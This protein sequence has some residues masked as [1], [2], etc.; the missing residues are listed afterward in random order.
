MNPDGFKRKPYLYALAY[1]SLAVLLWSGHWASVE[2]IRATL[3]EH[4]VRQI[5]PEPAL[6]VPVAAANQLDTL[7]SMVPAEHKTSLGAP[8]AVAA[9]VISSWSA[10]RNV[11][12]A[13]GPSVRIQVLFP[14]ND[15]GPARLV[16]ASDRITGCAPIEVVV[17]GM[18][19][20]SFPSE[21][22][23]VLAACCSFELSN[24]LLRTL[25]FGR[26]ATLRIES[27]IVIQ[28]LSIDLSGSA[29]AFNEAWAYSAQYLPEA[30]TVGAA[31]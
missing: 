21:S 6:N 30:T 12:S 10:S 2:G 1:T 18:A 7:A 15:T 26:H 24:T 16:V 23:C 9:E 3:R 31:N 20:G 4:T 27:P 8:A 19:F 29:A 25:K 5:A 14:M 13:N 17:D 11:A 28:P 22:S